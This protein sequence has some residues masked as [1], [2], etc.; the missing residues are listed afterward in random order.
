[1]R[2]TKGFTF[3]LVLQWGDPHVTT[4]DRKPYTFNGFGEYLLLAAEGDT[5]VVHA[6]MG[7]Y[8]TEN[9]FAKGT[10]Y[11]GLAAKGKD[12]PLIEIMMS[13]DKQSKWQLSIA[14]A[15][16]WVDSVNERKR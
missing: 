5:F 14:Q 4:L 8:Q 2:F 11:T 15:S 16:F 1:M 7:L 3:T 9:G 10:V 12:T 13:D 6:R